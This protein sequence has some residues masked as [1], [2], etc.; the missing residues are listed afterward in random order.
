MQEDPYICNYNV[1]YTIVHWYLTESHH[2][3]NRMCLCRDFDMQRI[4]DDPEIVVTDYLRRRN[5]LL[6]IG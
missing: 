1:M 6:T 3:C 5:R 4:I 2:K